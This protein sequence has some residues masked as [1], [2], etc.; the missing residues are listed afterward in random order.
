MTTPMC[1]TYHFD[2]KVYDFSKILLNYYNDKYGT[3]ID[4]LEKFHEILDIFTHEER[5]DLLKINLFG[6]NDRKSIFIKDFYSFIDNDPTFINLYNDFVRNI[7]KKIHFPKEKQILF[8]TTPNLRI[9]F[10]GSTSIGSRPGYDPEGVVGLH[11]DGEFGH[12][13]EELNFIIP[14]TL[15]F[16]TNSVYY[17]PEI[18]SNFD[19]IDYNV[20][21]L[22]KNQ[23]FT[24]K[25][26]KLKHYNR[27]N[28]TGQ[29]RVSLDIRVIPSSQ[30]KESEVCSV[31]SHK[32]FVVGDYYS[33]M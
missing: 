13:D 2:N 33:I 10:P 26:N 19:H 18:E 30:Y 28:I 20:V 23:Y 22:S 3:K 17:E 16:E 25:L 12:L 24:G 7:I 21:T 27:V 11:T 14:L 29:T 9:S 8:Q 5:E 31:S 4:S 15:M 1:S 6:V 32:K